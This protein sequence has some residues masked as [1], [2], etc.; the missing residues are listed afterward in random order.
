M[1]KELNELAE[2]L[3][4]HRISPD[5]YCT[6]GEDFYPGSDPDEAE[7]DAFIEAYEA[8]Q[9]AALFAAGYRKQGVL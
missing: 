5:F 2:T 1:S 9:S 6:C 8:H 4:T 3:A 7:P